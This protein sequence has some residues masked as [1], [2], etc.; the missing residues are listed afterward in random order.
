MLCFCLFVLLF[1]DS[2]LIVAYLSRSHCDRSEQS[3]A[4]THY[5]R[6]KMKDSKNRAIELRWYSVFVG[7]YVRHGILNGARSF[8][9]MA[10]V[11]PP[12]NALMNAVKPRGADRPSS[13]YI[14]GWRVIAMGL[15]AAVVQ[16]QRTEQK[17]LN[18][19]FENQN[20]T[21]R[22]N[23]TYDDINTINVTVTRV[24]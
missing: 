15:T 20:K 7:S 10:R 6:L 2:R 5:V 12:D 19:V 21:G 3:R 14:G 9:R 13:H 4:A 18:S 8:E 1:G 22:G 24:K 23:N 11:P 16:T 17:T